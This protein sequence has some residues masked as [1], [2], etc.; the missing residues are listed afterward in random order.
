MTEPIVSVSLG[1]SGIFLLG[2]RSKDI[3]PVPILLRSGDVV[4][5]SGESRYCYHGVPV[6]LSQGLEETMFGHLCPLSLDE[7]G[8]GRAMMTDSRE[9]NDLIWST[10]DL[11]DWNEVKAYLKTSRVNIN[12]RRVTVQDGYWENKNGSGYDVGKT[13]TETVFGEGGSAS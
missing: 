1:C 11:R 12:A 9:G 10:D 3:A 8:V 2:G 7:V 6:I 4:V 5:M 13:T